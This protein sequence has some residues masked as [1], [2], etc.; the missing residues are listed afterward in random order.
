MR[1][2]ARAPSLILAVL[3]SLIW[4]RESCVIVAAEPVL[5]NSPAL[6]EDADADLS[7]I[8]PFASNLATTEQTPEIQQV[9][10]PYLESG[11]QSIDPAM[12]PLGPRSIAD[13]VST[14]ETGRCDDLLLDYDPWRDGITSLTYTLIP[15]S[16]ENVSWSSFDLRHAFEVP[17]YPGLK[18]TPRF[19]WHL[20]DRAPFTQ[21]APYSFNFTDISP[22]LYDF[23]VDTSIILPI[24]ERWELQGSISPGMYTD[25]YN[26]SSDAF[27]LPFMAA[28]F[29]RW[30]PSVAFGVGAMYLDR[31]DIIAAAILGVVLGHPDDD[32]RMELFFPR[33]KIGYR[34]KT[35]GDIEHWFYLAQDYIGGGSWAMEHA[36]GLKDV[37][38]YRDQKLMLGYERMVTGERAAFIEAGYVYDRELQFKELGS[39]K[40][41]S[42]GALRMGFIF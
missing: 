42:T 30:S 34:F 14:D 28:A 11:A 18:I 12:T 41:S 21:L 20:V 4:G 10:Y 36:Y 22:E 32:L 7:S 25:F 9:Q 15:A 37:V 31:E 24:G 6:F 35:T 39:G 29:Y 23:A 40:L 8:D 17:R 5:A 13:T 19:S 1:L 26:V 33:T 27:R 38:S 16:R 3:F 2:P